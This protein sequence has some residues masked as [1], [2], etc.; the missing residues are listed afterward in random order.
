MRRYGRLAALVLLGSLSLLFCGCAGKVEQAEEPASSASAAVDAGYS[1]F[2]GGEET[3]INLDACFRS[4]TGDALS[5]T[6]LLS[7][8]QTSAP[9]LLDESG[10][11]RISGLPREGLLDVRL[12]DKDQ[13]ELGAVDVT[14]TTGEVIDASA[15][16]NGAGYVTLRKDT[17]AL[18][19][20]FV[21][22][23]QGHLWCA[24]LLDR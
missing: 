15:D 13:K 4:Q 6:A 11:V 23:E 21:A 10:Q 19:L 7:S 12:L 24:L 17:S 16:Q 3:G 8:G 5:G 2:P 14:F 18:S 9:Y 1:P 20:V 22:D